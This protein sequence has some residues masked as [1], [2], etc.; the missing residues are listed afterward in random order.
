MFRL[1]HVSILA[2]GAASPI[3]VHFLGEAAFTCQSR[4]GF[5]GGRL[6]EVAGF[7][8]PPVWGLRVGAA[9]ERGEAQKAKCLVAK[10]FNIVTS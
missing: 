9:G 3:R 8:R 2:V 6:R 7:N 1:N 4:I 5:F 10:G